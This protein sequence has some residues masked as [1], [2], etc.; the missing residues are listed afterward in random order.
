MGFKQM[1]SHFFF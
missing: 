1:Q